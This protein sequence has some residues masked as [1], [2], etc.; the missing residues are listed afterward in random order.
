LLFVKNGSYAFIREVRKDDDSNQVFLACDVVASRYLT[1]FY[2][3]PCNSSTLKIV[4]LNSL[5][6]FKRKMV[7]VDEIECKCL[8]LPVPSGGYALAPLIHELGGIL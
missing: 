7:T 4:F 8:C 5:R 3:S 6:Q 2:S 1:D